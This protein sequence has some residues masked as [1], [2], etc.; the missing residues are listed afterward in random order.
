MHEVIE[1]I[2]KAVMEETGAPTELMAWAFLIVGTLITVFAL[3]GLVVAVYLAIRYIR[4]NRRKNSAGMTG[5]QVARKILDRNHL[6]QID[7]TPSGSLIFGNSYSHYFKKVRLRRFT[8][9]K[10]SISSLAMAAQKSALAV[11]DKEGDPDM[12]RRNRLIPMITFGPFFFLPLIAI[13]IALDLLINGSTPKGMYTMIFAGFGLIF[14]LFS[15]ILSLTVL[16]V[17]KK[18]QKRAYEILWEYDL[19]TKEELEEI[20]KL[21]KLYNIQYVNDMILEFLEIIYRALQIITIMQG[22]GSGIKGQQN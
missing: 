17:E 21:F 11:L 6:Q 1:E 8:Y 18:G 20:R 10:D 15:F 14:Y 7:V 19:A 9:K 3:I 2:L 22:N 5:E 12:K 13:G 16:R 4:Y